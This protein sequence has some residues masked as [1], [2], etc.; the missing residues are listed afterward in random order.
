MFTQG[1]V[2]DAH[3]EKNLGRVRD[4]LEILQGFVELIVVVTA[5][6]RNPRLNFLTVIVSTSRSANSKVRESAR[7]VVP[8]SET[9]C[10]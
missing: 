7:D 9:C 5:K 1:S 10:R 2:D 4:L 6:G 3:V 8:V